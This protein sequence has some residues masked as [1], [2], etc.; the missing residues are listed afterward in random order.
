M[1]TPRNAAG[2][3]VKIRHFHL[4]AGLGG[5]ARGFNRGTA[6]VGQLQARFRC[7]GGVDVDPAAM[8]DF[9]RLA[10]V[11]GT[12]PVASTTSSKPP[13]RSCSALTRVLSLSCTPCLSTMRLK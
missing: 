11:R 2:S 1:N 9:E 4:F 3:A 10:G 6:R 7:I 12:I 5:G 8:R 13:S